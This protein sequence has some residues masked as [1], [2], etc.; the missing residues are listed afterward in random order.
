[1]LLLTYLAPHSVLG[2]QRDS[3]DVDQ[4]DTSDTTRYLNNNPFKP[5]F[6]YRDRY[7]DPFS[8]FT[9][10]SPFFLKDPASMKTNLEIDTGR[11]YSIHEKMGNVYYRAPSS[12]SFRDFNQNQS[13]SI[14]KEYW[15]NRSKALD[16]E[17]AVSSRNLIPRIYVSPVLDRI[18]GGSYVEII[19]RG[20]VTLDFG[21]SF[22]NIKNPAIPLRQQRNGGFEFDQQISLSV[23]GKI[24]EKLA[25]TTN[26]DNNNSFDFQNNMKVEYTG[27]KE[28]I[29]KKLELGNVSLPLN[30][31]LITGA[32]NLFG[33][34]A[35]MQFGKLFVTTIATT[36]RGKQN[37]IQVAG[38]TSGASQGRPFEVVG[39]N[40]DDN[41]HF[42]LSQYFRDNFEKW[43][44]NL[45]QVTS[46]VTI[47]RVEVYLM[48]R[49]NDTQTLRNVVG[50]M[51]MGEGDPY[52]TALTGRGSIVPSQ[53]AANNLFALLREKN[54]TRLAD[55]VNSELE[56][57]RFKAG[58]DFEKI[59]SA[60]KLAPTEFTFHKELGYITLSRKLQNDEALAVAFEYSING[61]NY[62]VGELTDDYS[63]LSEDAV[64][65]LKLLR[66]KKVSVKD[67][68][69][70]I[71]PTWN[72][73]MKNI[74][75]LN[76][77]GLTRDG[78]QLR[79]IYRDDRSG[80]DNPQLQEGAISKTKQLIEV[81]GLD[82]L[83]P[84]NDPQPD[85]NFDFVERL[86]VN[87]ETGLIIFPYLEPFNTP[88][89]KLFELD[90]DQQDY[91]VSKYVYDTLY[92]TTKA[93]AELVAT[94]NKFWLVGT[95]KSGSGKEIIIQ[96]FNITQGSV[97]VYAGG[98]PLREGA[99]YTVDYTFGKVTILNEGILS[100]GKDINITYEQQDPFA[101]QTRSLLG[102]RFDYRLSEDVNIGSTVLYYNERPLISRNLIGT[103]P[104]RN[105]QYGVDLNVKKNS[106]FL[107]KMVDALPFLQTKEIST[108]NLNAEFAQLLP[109]TS[110][111]VQ[112]DGTS[113][114]D[115]FENTATPTSLLN[116]ISW[117]LSTVPKTPD[118]RFDASGGAVDDITAGYKRAKLSWYQVDNSVFY[119]P[120]GQRLRPNNISDE[121]LSN[122]YVRKVGPQEIFQFRDQTLGNFNEQIL[123]VA[124]FPSERGP[125]N[126]NP[127]LNADG[128]LPN[129]ASNWAG[130]TTAI[131][132]E[133]DFDKANVEY[134]EF[135]MLDPFINTTRGKVDDGSPEARPNTT[136]GQLVFHLGSISEDLMRDGK[137]AFENGLPADGAATGT[138]VVK[139]QWG[140]VTNQQYLNDAFANENDARPNQDV[141]LDGASNTVERTIFQENF[142]NRITSASARQAVQADP[143][144]DDFKHFLSPDYDAQDA[145][146][147]G[148][149]KNFGGMEN[150]SPVATNAVVP[151]SSTTIPDN[152][153]LNQ[154]NTLSD[155]EEYYVYNVDLRPSTLQ[156]GRKY[157]FDKV[158]FNSDGEVVTWYLFRIPVRQ[159][160]EKVGEINDFKSIKYVRMYMT[161]F[162]QP[163]VLRFANFRS[164]GN[165]WRRYT[166]ELA[167]S[168]LAEKLEPNLDNFS[169]SVV[170]VE[171]NASPNDTKP[172]YVPPLNRDRDI[173]SVQQ[174][175]LNEQ[176]VQLCVTELPDG[177]ARSIYKNV[178]MDFFNY[179]RIKMFLSAHSPKGNLLDNELTGFLR[180][181]TDFDQNYYE[182]ELP[183]KVTAAGVNTL[184]GVWPEDNQIDLDLNELYALKASRDRAG[185]P[186]TEAFPRPAREVG[187]HRITVVGRPDLSQVKLMMIGVRN[188]R[189]PDAKVKDVC[190]WA[191]E[192]RL[193]D[194]DRTAGWASN[195]VL[196]TKLADLGT[197]TGSL[198][199]ITYG[200]GGVQSKIYER[201]RG[202]TTSYDV[203]ANIQLDKLLPKKL[204]LSIPVFASYESKILNP[205]FDPANP[206]MRLAA[207]LLSRNTDA[208]REEYIKL[209]RDKSIRRSLNFTNVRKVKVNKESPVRIW[210]VENFSFTYA[211]AEATQ[212]NFNLAE[213]T[214]RSV[215]GGVAWQYTPT[216]K[217]FEPFKDAKGLNSPY[218][219]LI[220]D[221]NFNPLPT[222]VTIRAELD[223]SFS[224][225]VYRNAQSPIEGSTAP[226]FVNSAANFQKYFVFNRFYNARWS[227]TKLLTL[228]Y[229]SR[230]NAIIDEPDGDI[231]TK[232]KYDSMVN[233]LKSFG[234]MKAFDQTATLNYTLPLDK[235][236]LTNWLGAEYRY[237]VGYSWK[238]GPLAIGSLTDPN[239]NMG[240]I[241]QNTRE[242]AVNGRVD[243][244]KLYNKVGFLKDI[245]TPKRPLTPLEKARQAKAQPDTVK[246]PPELKGVKALLRLLMS[247]RNVTGTYTMTEGTIL[248][249]FTATP[250]LFGMDKMWS[251]PG[252]DFVLGKQNI[253]P[254]RYEEFLTRSTR[255]TTPFSQQQTQDLSMRASVEPA[256]DLKIQLDVKRNSN[257]AFQEIYRWIDVDSAGNAVNAFGALSPNRTGSYRVSIMSIATAFDNNTSINSTV[258]EQFVT[259]RD[260]IRDRFESLN[261]S[262]YQVQSQ[263]VVIPAFIAAYTGKDANT[264]ALSPFPKMPI[265]N[266]RLDYNGL[267]K[268]GKLKDVFQSVTLSHA[269]SSTY[270]VTNFMNSLRYSNV[271]G[272]SIWDYN[273]GSNFGTEV[274]GQKEIVPIYVISQVMISE[275]FAPLVGVNVRT[276]NKLSARFEYKTKRDVS[277]NISN[278]QVTEMNNKDWAFEVGYTKNNLKLPFR[279]QG[280]VITLKNDVT[281]KLNMSLT[282]SQTIQRKPALDEVDVITNGNVN[283]QIRPN[284]SYVVN[285]KLNVQLYFDRNI[286]EPKVSNS[287]P[288]A[289]TKFGTKILFN[290][291]Q[292]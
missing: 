76:V 273:T 234:R 6:R 174:R 203:S 285:Q 130:I 242:Q 19:P 44:G 231:N 136:G 166:G 120:N 155:L 47:T 158:N 270:Q 140:Y 71:I 180:L 112:G 150:N 95:F 123:D 80:I 18:F 246:R 32:Q 222:N 88:L 279:D 54:V 144:A 67:A 111:I 160:D 206:D 62:K 45:P 261:T 201:A 87:P 37:S 264:V 60:R 39:S 241:I 213:N 22:Q 59:T 172:G 52:S 21:A 266:W 290:L 63:N 250:Y 73:M 113:F 1:M 85:G 251:Q 26:F 110:N 286:N 259:N 152:E 186:L 161:G 235:L 70:K 223:R 3:T 83:N 36:Q 169:V 5:S 157:I 142:L 253:D 141:G 154:D 228:D 219:A 283:I 277:L 65:F 159:F 138:N 61:Q 127:N 249:G 257:T 23:V 35:Q 291:A 167:E 212:T 4:V 183:L 225:I 236:P 128:T 289:T 216:F 275:Q 245:N 17:S 50:F 187:K 72:L 248:P 66:P 24:G 118:N 218:L 7:G 79:V 51:D 125:Y 194:F 268:I 282:N 143:S 77:Q 240:N 280:R 191:N 156:V 227:L 12:M 75:A 202:V 208:E 129:P 55:N 182:I 149:Y 272:I 42:F 56:A 124:Y 43:L 94:K 198:R 188:P 247:V 176:S 10:N 263:D 14:L 220:K 281:F 132:S 16:G 269:Y 134:I 96:G 53:N 163:V 98:T 90:K 64:I 103:E 210:D 151:Q 117:K 38:S 81:V 86:T 221:F 265:P 239:L 214:K 271:Q 13:R 229:S 102:T 267:N 165:R 119:L 122:H 135:W 29:L 25:V 121:D 173:T 28:D 162:T 238:A 232:Q 215:K 199:H 178:T 78:F 254:A 105:L 230:V 41:R 287:F 31:S 197:V 115:D 91:L 184:D 40:Y 93:E 185:A 209:I 262:G 15:Q 82:R 211:F 131:R 181:G 252:W 69:G 147:L 107:T 190:L 106:R 101:F 284:I 57:L 109:G 99:D 11:N 48:N 34:K 49:Q 92:H 68:T 175:R 164:V 177:D 274:N 217:G 146:V 179:G 145:T 33:V 126:Y 137:H 89:R 258:F 133:V 292:Q 153:D 204:G 256:S 116:R 237:N 58:T 207:A 2:Q 9:P 170:N 114:I 226:A 148:R 260:I 276:K 255:L 27:F 244:T 84:Y 243:L 288:R 192:L 20:F 195:V 171:E 8:N 233:N 74:Y 108:V 97:K 139:N 193:T 196:S 168:Q 278:G 104:A 205:N 100:S 30:N 46:G 189:S 224:K 200:Y